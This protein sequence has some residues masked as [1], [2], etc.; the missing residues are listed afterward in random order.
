MK[1][2]RRWGWPRYRTR[3]FLQMALVTAAKDL[4]ILTNQG[5]ITHTLDLAILRIHLTQEAAHTE[6]DEFTQGFC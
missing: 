3:L 2:S 1:P 5:G 4:I 6:P